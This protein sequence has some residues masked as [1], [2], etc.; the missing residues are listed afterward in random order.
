MQLELE[1]EIRLCLSYAQVQIYLLAVLDLGDVEGVGEEVAQVV[2]GDEVAD[3]KAYCE[4]DEKHHCCGGARCCSAD[5]S[6]VALG[7]DPKVSYF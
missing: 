7:G 6:C 5:S 3:E 1:R 2:V 4:S